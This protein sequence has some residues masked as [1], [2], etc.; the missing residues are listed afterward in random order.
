MLNPPSMILLYTTIVL[1]DWSNIIH[2]SMSLIICC[3]QAH[4]SFFF[5]DKGL[6][7]YNHWVLYIGLDSVS[8]L[9]KHDLGFWGRP[10]LWT[11]SPVS[12]YDA[13]KAASPSARSAAVACDVPAGP[14]AFSPILTLV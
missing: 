3:N 10:Q 1:F 7:I 14:T 9:Q 11:E 2:T 6:D 4:D 5:C 12:S 8:D 13:Q